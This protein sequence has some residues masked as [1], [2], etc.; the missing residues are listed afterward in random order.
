[1]QSENFVPWKYSAIR[2]TRTLA[3]IL[4][5]KHDFLRE[6]RVPYKRK[7]T[8]IKLHSAQKQR[9]LSYLISFNLNFNKILNQSHWTSQF[10]QFEDRL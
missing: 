4:N 3:V 9:Y 8:A 10:N 2:H 1:M 6:H 7:T 5:R